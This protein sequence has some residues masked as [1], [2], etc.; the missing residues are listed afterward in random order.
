MPIP[1]KGVVQSP[2]AHLGPVFPYLCRLWKIV[3][4][5]VIRYYFND[6][7]RGGF[8]KD[9]FSPEFVQGILKQLLLWGDSLPTSLARG[10]RGTHEVTI[11]Q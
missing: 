8:Q 3:H 10:N 4:N 6:K 2:P 11:M 9:R 1:A 5:V 7:S